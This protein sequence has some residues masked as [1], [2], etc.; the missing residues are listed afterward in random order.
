MADQEVPEVRA[1][2]SSLT[3]HRKCPQAWYYKY[4]LGLRKPQDTVAPER[5]FGSWWSVLRAAEA[6]E[7]GLALGSLQQEPRTVGTVDGAPKIDLA[8]QGVEDVLRAMDEWWDHHRNVPDGEGG[9]ASDQWQSRLGGAAPSL[10]SN[11]LDRHLDQWSEEIKDE[12]PLGVEVFWERSLP[13]PKDDWASVDYPDMVLTGY[14]D[15]LFYSDRRKMVV[16]RDDKT[17]KNLGQTSSVDDM[18]DSQ[19]QLYAWGANPLV[20]SWGYDDGIRAVAYDRAKSIAP[21]PPS[22]T[23]SGRLRQYKG[24]PTIGMMDLQTYLDWCASKPEFP[25]TKKDGSGAGIYEAE[26]S[27]IQKL[28]TVTARA[29]W[30]QRSQM[31]LNRN[32][33]RSHL[34]SAVDSAVDQFTT[35]RRAERTLEAQRNLTSACKWCDFAKLCRAQMV[36]GSEGTYELQELDL[37]GRRGETVLD[38]GKL[39]TEEAMGAA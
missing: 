38:G 12:R 29:N 33:V 23:N 34:R 16:A 21:K 6:T 7:R 11:L 1:H 27:V 3:L 28:S 18:M 9:F 5:D 24:E 36:G 20:Q 35:Q 32:L 31:P 10:L 26:E 13:K 8:T 37:R 19:L 30:F 25:G 14:I 17:T 2:Y 4:D 39:T 22:L 15:E